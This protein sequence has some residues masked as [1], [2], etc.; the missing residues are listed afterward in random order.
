MNAFVLSGAANR[1]AMEA[2]A[3]MALF[4]AGI[5]P[6]LVAGSS[7]GA[8]NAA[9]IAGVPT[10]EGARRLADIWWGIRKEDVLPGSR[11]A[12]LWRFSRRGDRLYDLAGLE[13]VLRRNLPYRNLED[14]RVPV[15]VVA[16]ELETGRECWFRRGDA[17]RAVLA[18]TALPGVFP[19]V[20]VDGVRYIDGGV[21]NRVPIS[22]AAAMGADR[23]Y[24]IDVGCPC[25][26]RRR[27]RSALEILHR[28]VGILESQRL[29]A[30]L[31]ADTGTL[32]VVYLPLPC[33]L[34][35]RLTD[36]S[37]TARLIHD[38]YRFAKRAL[39][40]PPARPAWP[41]CPPVAA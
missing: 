39:S 12:A 24:V 40:S 8:I 15:V 6:D 36:F 32:E 28:A 26:C 30:E 5:R 38:G 27:Y 41:A 35:V 31:T 10:P 22:V 33:R 34:P 19:P 14:A 3:L 7:A 23:A 1:G 25:E 4:E 18:S 11:L 13:R 17:A 29:R 37:R 2:G 21:T 20:E 9:F 16:T